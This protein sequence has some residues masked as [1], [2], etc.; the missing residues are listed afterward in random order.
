MQVAE[1]AS[2]DADDVVVPEGDLVKIG[3]KVEGQLGIVDFAEDGGAMGSA[4]GGEV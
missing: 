1:A 2:V 3:Q 4:G